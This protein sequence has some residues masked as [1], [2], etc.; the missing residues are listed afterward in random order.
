M[1]KQNKTKQN[2][3]LKIIKTMAHLLFPEIT[4]FNIKFLF[5]T[6]AKR[7]C[8]VFFC[9]FVKEEMFQAFYHRFLNLVRNENLA[10]HILIFESVKKPE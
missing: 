2:H 3:F 1:V 6:K 5:L 10:S 4:L 9:F 7:F 8:F